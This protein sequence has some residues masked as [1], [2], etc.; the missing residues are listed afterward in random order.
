MASLLREKAAHYVKHESY[1]VETR[2]R[3]DHTFCGIMFDL[4]VRSRRPVAFIQIE[5]LW[6][7][8]GL[9]GMTV[10]ATPGGFTGKHEDESA[11]TK[12]YEKD[13]NRR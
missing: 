8:G 5:E 13:H 12:I 11:W 4:Q 7:R 1:M 6:V 10:W 3:E 2:D 9:G